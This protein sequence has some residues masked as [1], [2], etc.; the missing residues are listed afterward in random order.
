MPWSAKKK[1]NILSVVSSTE[2]LKY[3]GL[4]SKNKQ[5]ILGV[6]ETKIQKP[7]IL[8]D[9]NLPPWQVQGHLPDTKAASVSSILTLSAREKLACGANKKII[10][11]VVLRR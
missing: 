10:P 1:K 7:D 8:M 6:K 4:Y 5:T 11:T 3:Q 2:S 9:K